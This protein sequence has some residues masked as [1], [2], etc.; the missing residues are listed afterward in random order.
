M[1]D[2]SDP[3]SV[4]GREAQSQ[5]SADD[6][7]AQLE[8][9]VASPD[10]DVPAR[11]RRF[12]RYIV[13]ETLAGRGDRIK[14]YSIGTRGVRARPELRRPERS[15]RADRG[16][17]APPRPRAL[18]SDR[19]PVRSRHH[20]RSRRAPTSHTSPCGPSRRRRSRRP[21][22]RPAGRGCANRAAI[23]ASKALRIGR[24][25]GS[26]RRRLRRHRPCG[27]PRS[28]IPQPSCARHRRS[29]RRAGR[30]SSSCRLR[31]LGE[32]PEAKIYAEGLD[33]GG[34]EPARPLQGA[35][36]P[37]TGDVAEHPAGGRRRP[38]PP[39]TRR[40]VRAGGQR[41]GRSAPVC[42]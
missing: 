19:R 29:C 15:G 35:V 18:L 32:G 8:R 39:R 30:P 14:A 28:E 7:R 17:P 1:L 4:S 3:L 31:S 33:R 22:D 34:P 16:R 24:G 37:R 2:R 5:P 9:L 6:V 25:R 12:L 26:A 27:A 42:A 20:R 10:L 40:P 38:D 13:E 23:P 36:R 11:A 41:P 21:P